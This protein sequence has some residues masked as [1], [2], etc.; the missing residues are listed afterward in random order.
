MCATCSWES[1]HACAACM[2]AAHV[3]RRPAAHWARRLLFE[4]R[5]HWLRS[6]SVVV[7]SPSAWAGRLEYRPPG[8]RCFSRGCISIGRRAHIRGPVASAPPRALTAHRRS[9]RAVLELRPAFVGAARLSSLRL[10]G[11]LLRTGRTCAVA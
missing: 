2:R 7:G 1:L 11:E 4:G 5:S 6:H 10:C 9:A 8:R 3:S